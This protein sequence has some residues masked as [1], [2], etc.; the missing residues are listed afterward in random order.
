MAYKMK[1]FPRHKVKSPVKH[2]KREPTEASQDW[3]RDN[4]SVVI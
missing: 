3:I 4:A 2:F 1:G